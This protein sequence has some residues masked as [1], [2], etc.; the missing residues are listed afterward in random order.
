MISKKIT[1]K[2]TQYLDSQGVSYR[3]LPHSEPVF[4]VK[5]A[6]VQRG[7]VLEEMV[8]CI[9]LRERR[10]HRYVMACVTGNSHL[11]PQA[12]R[13]HLPGSWKRLSF[14]SSE[15]ITANTGYTKGS[16]APLC[17]PEHIPVVFDEAIAHCTKVNISSG[18]SMAGLELAASDLIRLTNPIIGSIAKSK[19]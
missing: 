10:K 4:T 13:T 2:I 17:M 16:V 6:A 8:K 19:A 7:V 14:A 15:E 5:M 3:V 18:D 12:V 1:T 9:L 11:D